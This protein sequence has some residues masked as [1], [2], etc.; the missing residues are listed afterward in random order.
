MTKDDMI[1]TAQAALYMCRMTFRMLVLAMWIGYAILFLIVSIHPAQAADHTKADLLRSSPTLLPEASVDDKVVRLSDI[2]SGLPEGEDAVIGAAPAPGKTMIVNAATLKR[3]ANLYG[4]EWKPSSPMDQVVVTRSSQTVTSDT[5]TRTIKD[6][7]TARGVEGDF[8]I[9]LGGAVPSITLAGDEAATVEISDLT[10]TAGRDV[11]TAVLAAPSVANPVKTMTV[12]GVIE[13]IRSVPV[14]KSALQAGD[15]IG[16]ADIE[17]IPVNNRTVVYD[18]VLD[19]DQMIGKTPLRMADAGKPLRLR[20]LESPQLV[21]RGDEILIQFSSGPLQL[22]AKGKAMQPGAEG[23]I[24][25][26]VNQ[27]SNQSLRGEVVGDK[28]VRVQ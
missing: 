1:D 12:S 18:T 26:V 14:L 25:R 9:T 13:K 19:P 7:L 22:T 8:D 17:F 16:A 21:A 23:D 15:V 5:I 4:L 2:F 3:V 24:I 6:A 20:D 28:T 27:A 10:Y 11:F